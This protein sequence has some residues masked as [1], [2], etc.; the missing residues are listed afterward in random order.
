M[1]DIS[2]Q[3]PLNRDYRVVV[4]QYV[5]LA[6]EQNPI[7]RIMPLDRTDKAAIYFRQQGFPTGVMDKRG[8]DGTPVIVKPIPQQ[9]YCWM[10]EVYANE[11][12]ITEKELTEWGQ[13]DNNAGAGGLVDLTELIYERTRHLVTRMLNRIIKNGW[14]FL[15]YGNYQVV[16]RVQGSVVHSD[17]RP[18]N[19]VTAFTPWSDT[20]NSDPIADMYAWITAYSQGT[21]VNYASDATC[22]GA[23]AYMNEATWAQMWANR[24]PNSLLWGARGALGSTIGINIGTINQ[25]MASWGLPPIYILSGDQRGYYDDNGNFQKW[26]PDGKVVFVGCGVA[27]VGHFW[28]TRNM[29]TGGAPEIYSDYSFGGQDPNS[30]ILDHHAFHAPQVR[31]V[32]DFNGGHSIE[33]PWQIISATVY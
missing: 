6:L 27:P 2:Y 12:L 32:V 18:I 10:P 4:A 1:P 21:T 31:M 7:F 3:L 28:L 30:P 13:F 20:L 5:P 9:L 33:R 19:Q 22:F 24:N 26:I 14:D 23:G 15:V 16:E 25:Y 11:S 8:Y 29:L 17:Y